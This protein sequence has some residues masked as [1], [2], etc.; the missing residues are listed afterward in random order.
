MKRFAL[1]GAAGYIA[2]RHRNAIKDTGNAHRAFGLGQKQ[3]AAVRRQPPVVERSRHFL[4][5]NRWESETGNATVGHGGL[6][7]FCSGSK[8]RL[9]RI[10]SSQISKLSYTYQPKTARLINNAG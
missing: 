4:A 9:S 8:R 10:S 3:H 5:P 2:P 7:T 6:G 1:I